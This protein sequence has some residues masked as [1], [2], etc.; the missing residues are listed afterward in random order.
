MYMN[1]GGDAGGVISV[2]QQVETTK[3]GEAH[4]YTMQTIVCMYAHDDWKFLP[5]PIYEKSGNGIR[6]E[7]GR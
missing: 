4:L 7:K 1:I 5:K 6:H 3:K 2:R